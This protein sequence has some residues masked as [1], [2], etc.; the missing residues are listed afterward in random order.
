MLIILALI[1]PISF[2]LNDICEVM[3]DA[4]T[5]KAQF[6]KYSQ[7]LGGEVQKKLELCLFGDGMISTEF[8]LEDNFAVFSDMNAGFDEF[9][10]S[11][12]GIPE[13]SK[14]AQNNIVEITS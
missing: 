6:M 3:N 4:I 1:L 12:D 9:F 2:V 13:N 10:A 8:G 7:A 11:T 14:V 5:D